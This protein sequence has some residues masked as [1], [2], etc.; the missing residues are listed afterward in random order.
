[1]RAKTA[2]LERAICAAQNRLAGER[3]QQIVMARAG[4]VRAG[5]NCVDNA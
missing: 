3:V 2:P 4:L 5:Q 1:M